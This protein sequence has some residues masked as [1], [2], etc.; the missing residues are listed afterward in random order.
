MNTRGPKSGA[1][2]VHSPNCPQKEELV[3]LSLAH[4]LG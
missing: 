3:S 4:R 2:Q 1:T